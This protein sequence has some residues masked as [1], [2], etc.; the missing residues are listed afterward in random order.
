MINK[1]LFFLLISLL[2]TTAFGE[3]KKI[4]IPALGKNAKKALFVSP[5]KS[6]KYPGIVYMHGGKAREFGNSTFFEDKISD[7]ASMGF[8]VLAP[9][10]NTGEGCCN[11]DDA[12]KEGIHIAKEAAKYLRS[13]PNVYREKICLVGFSEGALISMWV[14]TEANDYSTA[15]IKSAST[16]CGMERAGAKKYCAKSLVKSG[17]LQQITKKIVVTYGTLDRGAHVKT[18]KKFAE[19]LSVKV[20]VLDGN[21]VSFLKPRKDINLIIRNN[22]S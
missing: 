15:I 4:P 2:P 22:C 1:C 20:N 10:R 6:G 3:I 13:L 11:G 17:K 12:I 19:K 18:A 14:M 5:N 21:H 7:W 16:Q 8:I 9:L